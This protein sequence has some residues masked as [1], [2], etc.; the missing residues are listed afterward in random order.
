MRNTLIVI[1]HEI[2]TTLS[3]RSFW[4]TTLLLPL[5]ILTFTLVPQFLARDAMENNALD[6]LAL[7][8]AGQQVFGYVDQAGLVKALPPDIPA[9]RLLVFPDE[10]AAQA[11]LTAGALQL[12]YIVPAD[13][14]ASGRLILVDRQFSPLS[15]FNGSNLI[16]YVLAYNL[17][18][19]A[20]LASLVI[21]PTPLVSNQSLAPQKPAGAQAD[22]ALA[23]AV[24]FGVMFILFFTITMS[25]GYMLQS[26]AAEKEN[27]TAEVLLVSLRP[28]ELMLG[29]VLGLGVVA[30]MQMGLWLGGGALMLSQGQALLAAAGGFTLPSGFF[31][32]AVLY[33]VGGYML[34]GS[35]LGALGA[36]VPNVREGSQFTFFFLLPLM[37]PLWLNSVFIQ[38][39]N[40]IVATLLSLF[41]LTAPTSM[42]TR[43]ASSPVPLW[44]LLAGLLLLAATAYGFVLLAARFFRA[45]TLLSSNSLNWR[46]IVDELRA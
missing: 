37:V 26:V 27:R 10:A 25:G 33:F 24:P 19:D 43:L 14:M 21:D 17:V 11:A 2:L 18:D 31:I 32:W 34:Y 4:A 5:A 29:K 35:A 28:A 9:D 22:S 41:P 16:E 13:F 3:K 7:V 1:K 38:N 23:F 12:Y 45:D 42:V 8:E 20:R 40:G 15:S 36:L 46:R 39:P 44:Q 6:P 30:L